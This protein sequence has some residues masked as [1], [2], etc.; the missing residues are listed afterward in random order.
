MKLLPVSLAETIRML[1]CGG[2]NKPGKLNHITYIIIEKIMKYTTILRTLF[3]PLLAGVILVACKKGED[4]T[5]L[6]DKGNTFIK[7]LGGGGDPVVKAMDIDPATE[8]I[9]VLD[10]RRDASSNAML[11]QPAT[12]TIT[13]TQV[14]L[15]SY[16]VHNGTNYEILPPASYT[17]TPASGVTVSGDTWTITL[18]PGEFA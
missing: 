11:N 4:I 7:L 14:F 10:V 16:N 12:I 3:V 6:G 5:D 2:I 13:N 15:D 8:T 1:K 18:A 9:N 17:I